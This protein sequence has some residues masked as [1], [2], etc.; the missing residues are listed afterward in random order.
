MSKSYD[1]INEYIDDFPA[2]VRSKLY[3]LKTCI[4]Q[5][6][7]DAKELFNYGIP[8][9]AFV[10][11]GKREDQ[12]MIAGYK[13]HVGLYPHPMTIEYFA[14]ELS[15]YKTGKGSVQFPINLELP[16]ELIDRMLK[17]RYQFIKTKYD[18]RR[19]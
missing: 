1:S 18:L 10:D 16:T 5:V 17:Y 15:M 13:K 8:A 7:P 2:E 9:F 14:G 3:D 6:V 4:L 19:L 11:S 12:V